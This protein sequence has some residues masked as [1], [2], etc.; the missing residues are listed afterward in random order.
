MK[1]IVILLSFICACLVSCSEKTEPGQAGNDDTVRISALLPDR[2]VATRAL[3]IPSTHK[4]RCILEVWTAGSSSS[5][6][7]REEV[8][9]E[10]GEIP[11]FEFSLPDGDY[12]C[13][14]WADIIDRNAEP[15]ESGSGSVSY[16]HFPDM[17]YNTADLHG[18]TVLD[19]AMLFD[20]DLCDAFFA[21]LDLKKGS[22]S[23]SETLKLARPSTKLVVREKETDRL[24]QL[25]KLKAVYTVPGGF[26]VST[27]EPLPSTVRLEYEKEYEWTSSDPTLFTCYIFASSDGEDRLGTMDLVFTVD[28]DLVYSIDGGIIPLRRNERILASGSLISSGSLDP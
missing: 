21:R 25:K 7:Y 28:Q 17:C 23:V 20:S 9:V 16:S 4:L 14:V 10:A 22:G 24:A 26:N 13:L 18:V 12:E 3:S 11:G 27:G 6:S 2:T 5:L 15:E 19:Q 1:R 8:A